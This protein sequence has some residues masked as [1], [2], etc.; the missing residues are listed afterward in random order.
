MASLFELEA[1]TFGGK[2]L[3][4]MTY[5]APDATGTLTVAQTVDAILET[6]Q[7]AAIT[8]T[9][10]TA[11]AIKAAFPQAVAGTSFELVVIN[12]GSNHNVTIQGGDSVTVVGIATVAQFASKVFLG[13]FVTATTIK[14]FGL[15]SVA[16]AQ[17]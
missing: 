8:L 16:A 15:G 17:S 11:A 13:Y 12:S 5:A 9:T 3:S 1:P 14:L 2:A 6:E 7:S 4:G 10:P